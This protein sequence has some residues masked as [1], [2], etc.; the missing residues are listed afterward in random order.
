MFN[1]K[2]ISDKTAKI[3]DH[4]FGPS[5]ITIP[6]INPNMFMPATTE[7]NPTESEKQETLDDSV[8]FDNLEDDPTVVLPT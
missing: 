6:D 8:N 3:F 4:L 5:S 1:G 2:I 7:V